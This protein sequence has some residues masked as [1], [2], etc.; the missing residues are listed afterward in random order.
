LQTLLADKP[1]PEEAVHL[2]GLLE[3]PAPAKAGNDSESFAIMHLTKVRSKP[4]FQRR[5]KDEAL[6]KTLQSLALDQFMARF[7]TDKAAR[8]YLEAVRWPSGPI[9]VHCG[10][11]D[12][13]TIYPIAPNRAK[14]IRE[15]LRECRQCGGQFTVTVGTIFED[16]KVPLRKWLVAWHMLCT[17]KKGVSALQIQ[18]MLKLGS[19]RTAWFMMHR[20]RYALR[21][22]MSADKLVLRSPATQA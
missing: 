19:Y 21:D 11:S 8:A 22:P 16:S 5:I 13:A 7:G 17:S 12:Q 18:R 2:H 10:N 20:I 4:R 14:K 6:T 1:Y 15:G 9:C 3:E